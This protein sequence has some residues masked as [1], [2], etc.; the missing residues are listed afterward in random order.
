MF[1]VLSISLII[2]FKTGFVFAQKLVINEVMSAN[3]ST[4]ADKDGD[5][6]DWIEIYNATVLAR[7]SLAH[8]W[9]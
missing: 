6:P 1:R 8:D 9:I 7:F 4:I 2:I 3:V 5:Y